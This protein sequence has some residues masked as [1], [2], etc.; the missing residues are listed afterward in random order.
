MRKDDEMTSGRIKKKVCKMWDRCGVR[1]LCEEFG[2]NSGGLYSGL[3]TVSS[4]GT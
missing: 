4:F 1:L 2:S 3:A